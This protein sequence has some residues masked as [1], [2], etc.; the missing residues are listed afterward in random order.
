MHT[1]PKK[2]EAL[3]HLRRAMEYEAKGQG[4]K[5]IASYQAAL[6]IGRDNPLCYQALGDA[7]RLNGALEKA[8][9][10]YEKGLKLFPDHEGL[11]NNLAVLRLFQNK[12]REV[13]RLCERLL[14]KEPSHPDA[15]AKLAWAKQRAG[16]F[17][18]AEISARRAIALRPESLFAWTVLGDSLRH[19]GRPLE[20]IEAFHRVLALEPHS[21]DAK[22]NLAVLYTTLSEGEKA[23]SYL[24]AA[25]SLNPDFVPA[26]IAWAQYSR[27]IGEWKDA[28]DAI[29]HALALEPENK[30]ALTV[31]SF[32][33]LHRGE[34][35]QGWR[36]YAAREGKSDA[37]KRENIS[38]P[39]WQGETVKGA[40]F[41]AKEQGIGDEIMFA[42]LFRE[43]AQRADKLII[44]CDARL[45]ALFE[46]SF[47]DISFQSD[48]HLPACEGWAT[49]GDLCS[50]F[51][52][53]E[54]S[55][56]KHPGY[57]LAS[58]DRTKEL[59]QKYES[60][61]PGKK[62]I[63]IAWHSQSRFS[64]KARSLPFSLLEKIV[65]IPGAAFLSLQYGKHS[66]P[67]A[68]YC[69]ESVDPWQDIDGLA[70]QISAC[71]YVVTIDNNV[72]HLAGALNI[73]TYLLLPKG[74]DWRWF[75]GGLETPWYPSVTLLRQKEAG[76]W[77]NVLE[78][79]LERLSF[80]VRSPAAFLFYAG[81]QE[82]AAAYLKANPG[83]GPR[84]DFILAQLSLLE[85]DFAK[86]W[87]AY[88]SRFI[89]DPQ[90][91]MLKG[92]WPAWDGDWSKPLL[93]WGEQGL[94]EEVLFSSLIPEALK[95]QADITLLCDPRMVSLFQRSFPK[96]KILGRGDPVSRKDLHHLP[97]GDLA[98]HF[99]PGWN[100]FN[101]HPS[102]WL[103]PD[104]PLVNVFRARYEKLA[105]GKP[106]LGLSW[107]SHNPHTGKMRSRP[108]RDL[109]QGARDC[110]VVS[111][112]YRLEEEVEGIFV[113]SAIDPATDIEAWVA[114]MAAMDRLWTIDNSVANLAGA[115]GLPARVYLSR[116]PDWRWLAT[117]DRTPWYPALKLVREDGTD[118]TVDAGLDALQSGRYFYASAICR[119]LLAVDPLHCAP[120]QILAQAQAKRG[121]TAE[122][123]DA[124]H[125]AL[126]LDPVNPLIHLNIA[127]LASGEEAKDALKMAL[128]LAPGNPDILKACQIFAYKEALQ[129]EDFRQRER[130]LIR[131][132]RTNPQNADGLANLSGL[133]FNRHAFRSAA[134]AAE[135]ALRLEPHHEIAAQNLAAARL[136]LGDIDQA[137]ALLNKT[138]D[139]IQPSQRQAFLL[140]KATALRAKGYIAEARSLLDSAPVNSD[141][142][143]AQ[144]MLELAEGKYEKGW[145]YYRH[146]F[147][148]SKEPVRVT[149]F[150]LP[151]WQGQK[152]IK[153][154]VAAEQGLGDEI[155]F[156]QF[157]PL[158][159]SRVEHI[160]L[161]ID[162]R[163]QKLYWRSFPSIETFHRGTLDR[164]SLMA[165]CQVALGDLPL[166]LSAKPTPRRY[167][168]PDRIRTEKL[169]SAY[170]QQFPD[171]KLI[172]ISWRSG[173][174]SSGP[175]RSFAPSGW[176]DLFSSEEYAFVSLQYDAKGED[177]AEFRAVGGDIFIDP[178]IDSKNDIEALAAQIAAMDLIITVDNSIAH[179]AGGM[180]RPVHLLLCA[181]PDWRWP[182]HG[183]TTDW[184]EKMKIFRLPDKKLDQ[185][186][187]EIQE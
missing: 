3:F 42:S 151:Q 49:I 10:V 57:L 180:G 125:K 171:K 166:L 86:G 160:Q 83:G 169:R 2:E 68:L 34:F 158:L 157:L 165:D 123:L 174:K 108:W 126:A 9:N 78:L 164:E 35:V 56:P 17:G 87:D 39:R 85:G 25:L 111:L 41:L 26:L 134:K 146:R 147:Y 15:L 8:E 128:S 92:D 181:I 79:L 74:C 130:K 93:I 88:A 22:T 38:V 47:P 127:Q 59:K 172:G 145:E 40:L 91:A 24:Q 12:P 118:C 179:I 67:F 19:L 140:H 141:T 103:R 82:E 71:D 167:L 154:F 27:S 144:A 175:L 138:A 64:G 31:R 153:L 176:S 37:Y 60:Q 97:I 98:K 156:A 94:G 14:G 159:Q 76:N 80:P 90:T 114:Q 122:A 120:W 54:A 7:W 148:R 161:E 109:L 6:A 178:A 46:R 16:D 58:P 152:G 155:M 13:G 115:L 142:R 104:P 84:E 29:D 100:A 44:E 163:L 62:R 96:L 69:D 173:N 177:R 129:E 183:D 55:F 184:Y 23:K 32:L 124:L 99:R 1:M 52:K 168:L 170:R 33:R 72:A 77:E 21:V 61:F 30:D 81:K 117:G 182:I 186:I 149:D 65:E 20:A 105:E 131:A 43:A 89:A 50:V 187:L 5:A 121:Y 11:L 119:Q 45:L 162:S 136:E 110:F 53:D 18:S 150:R 66:L 70:A 102:S 95:R 28:T 143:F 132:W 137:M 112:Q 73:P 63:G 133:L 139:H 135:K 101:D 4:E 51:R 106:I 185:K 116:V 48:S 75:G 113:D 36:D 107:L